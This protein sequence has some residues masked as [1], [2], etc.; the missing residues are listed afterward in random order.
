MSFL[1]RSNVSFDP[2]GV[3]LPAQGGAERLQPRSVAL[4]QMPRYLS[5]RSRNQVE[6]GFTVC[7]DRNRSSMV[8]DWQTIGAPH[9]SGAPPK[10]GAAPMRRD[11]IGARISGIPVS[12]SSARTLS[13][14]STPRPRNFSGPDPGLRYAADAATL[15]PGLVERP[16]WGRN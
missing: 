3:V 7:R 13:S 11:S 10:S 4:G 15:R 2:N 6:C 12:V 1:R 14:T 16:R 5:P 9:K 8:A